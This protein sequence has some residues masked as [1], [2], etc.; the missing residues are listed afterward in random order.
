MFAC[1]NRNG[2]ALK[3]PVETIEG[4]DDPAFGRFGPNSRPMRGW[5]LITRE[6]PGDYEQ[7][8]A[9]IEASIAYVVEQAASAIPKPPRAPRKK[10]SRGA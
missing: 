9:L 8:A 6:Q 3:L 2:L 1:V 10:S 5:L 4:L 7:D